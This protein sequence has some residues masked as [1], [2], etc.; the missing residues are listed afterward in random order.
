[1]STAAKT[2]SRALRAGRSR[3]I[4]DP[5]GVPSHQA[6]TA[7][8]PIVFVAGY[9]VVAAVIALCVLVFATEIPVSGGMARARGVAGDGAGDRAGLARLYGPS[10]L[11]GEGR[12]GAL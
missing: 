5:R 2:V 10:R 12:E 11:A 4:G 7:G 8:C 9:Y 1:M 6:R 3:G